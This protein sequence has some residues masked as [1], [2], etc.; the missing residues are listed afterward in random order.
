MTKIRPERLVEA[1][2]KRPDAFELEPKHVRA[3]Y[4]AEVEAKRKELEK[5]APAPVEEVEKE[6]EPKAKKAPAKPA[7][8]K[9]ESKGD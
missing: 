6:P 7:A 3:R 4:A 1:W 2:A 8:E 9:A 5:K